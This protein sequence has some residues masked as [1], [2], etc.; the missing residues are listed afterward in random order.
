ME[1]SFSPIDLKPFRQD[2]SSGNEYDRYG[3]RIHTCAKGS[4]GR[5]IKDQQKKKYSNSQLPNLLNIPQS[6]DKL[7]IK[8]MSTENNHLW[9]RSKLD[10]NPK[11]EDVERDNLINLWKS[12]PLSFDE[13]YR[14]TLPGNEKYQGKYTT[15]KV[16]DDNNHTSKLHFFLELVQENLIKRM[17]GKVSTFIVNAMSN[18]CSNVNILQIFDKTNCTEMLW[19]ECN[20][21]NSDLVDII[22]SCFENASRDI[23]NKYHRLLTSARQ[24]GR[25]S[26]EELQRQNP[27]GSAILVRPIPPEDRKL[28][29]SDERNLERDILNYANAA[30]ESRLKI[31]WSDVEVQKLQ[32][33]NS[34]TSLPTGSKEFTTKN[35]RKNET[36]RNVTRMKIQQRLKEGQDPK[37]LFD[38]DP[39]SLRFEDVPVMMPQPSFEYL[40]PKRHRDQLLKRMGKQ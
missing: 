1:S 3:H 13:N 24:L 12:D 32:F 21:M 10:N 4:I 22:A 38:I 28:H 14:K 36:R 17:G 19:Q 35:L 9:D 30:L 26:N 37:T 20:R 5:F 18:Y 33:E 16:Q 6:R 40:L 29:P 8:D 7:A 27:R 2:I 15:R 11:S 25:I 23:L 31:R 34:K 39:D